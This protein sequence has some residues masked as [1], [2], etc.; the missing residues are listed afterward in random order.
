[1]GN[2]TTDD[3]VSIYFE[4]TGANGSQAVIF[5]HEFAGEI[6]S[7][8]AQVAALKADYR[9]IAYAA[10]GWLPS[11]IPKDPAA[12]GIERAVADLVGLMDHLKLDKCH[13][14][15]LSMG[16]NTVLQTALWHPELCL[17]LTLSST[18]YGA[19]TEGR[20]AFQQA[21]R[22]MSQR[23]IDE[24]WES[25]AMEYGDGPFR[26]SFKKKHPKAHGEF[27]KRLA[28]HSALGSA[29]TQRAVQAQRPSFVEQEA[30]L[31]ALT[32]PTLLIVGDDDQPGFAGTLYL[33]QTIPT[34]G[35]YVAPRT[36]HQVNL[37]EPEVFNRVLRQFL[38]AADADTWGVHPGSD[39]FF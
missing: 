38:S 6:E 19:M 10:R 8:K 11:D 13:L 39:A 9:C 3:G 12:Y 15:G 20:A 17:S 29:L 33:K 25:M 14:V 30:A 36:G 35:L 24:G 1:M 5:A 7:W 22:E 32:L 28:G 2:F 26:Q 27:L 23:L 21:C 18:G 4:D 16:S 37:E 31:K 34:A